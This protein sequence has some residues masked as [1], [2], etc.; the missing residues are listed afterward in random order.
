MNIRGAIL[1][2]NSRYARQVI[3]VTDAFRSLRP[4][5]LRELLL[6]KSNTFGACVIFDPED[7]ILFECL[8]IEDRQLI[9]C[10]NIGIDS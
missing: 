1:I 10:R 9:D 5:Y 7:Y 8:A 6:G 2:L 4:L 3:E